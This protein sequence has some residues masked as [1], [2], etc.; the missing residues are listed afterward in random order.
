M[1]GVLK[2]QMKQSMGGRRY[3]HKEIFTLLQ[4]TAQTVK[5]RPLAGGA[6]PGVQTP[7]VQQD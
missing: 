1:I 7:L 3:S 4:E 5:S 2:K 6:V